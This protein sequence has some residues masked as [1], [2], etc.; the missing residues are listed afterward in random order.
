MGSVIN[1]QGL[2]VESITNDQGLKVE[3]ITNDQGLKVE[4]VTS[5]QGLGVELITNDQGLK[6]SPSCVCSEPGASGGRGTRRALHSESG[7]TLH[8]SPC[9]SPPSSSS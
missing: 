9:A 8:A 2:K 6:V 3:S 7:D 1:D 4:S 5:D